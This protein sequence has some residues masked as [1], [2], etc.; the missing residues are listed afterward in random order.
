MI[1]CQCKGISDSTIRAA[2]RGGVITACEIA[3]VWGAGSDCGGCAR[4][5]ESIL[6]DAV[7]AEQAARC[8]R[9]PYAPHDTVPEPAF[10]PAASAS[11]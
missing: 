10:V 7:C 5:V 3:R 1:V 2:V 11:A 4:T 6:E 8:T 9:V